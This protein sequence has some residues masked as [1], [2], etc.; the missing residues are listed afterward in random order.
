M[1]GKKKVGRQHEAM[2]I[3]EVPYIIHRSR[4]HRLKAM[5]SAVVYMVSFCVRDLTLRV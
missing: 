2:L 4:R 5:Y 1:K 3:R